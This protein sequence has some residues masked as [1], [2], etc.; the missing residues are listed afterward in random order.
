MRQG[1][2]NVSEPLL[3]SSLSSQQPMVCMTSLAMSTSYHWRH[4]SS[5]QKPVHSSLR[6]LRLSG[7]ATVRLKAADFPRSQFGTR[8]S[9]GRVP[10]FTFYLHWTTD[11]SLSAGFK[12]GISKLVVTGNYTL[13][14][15]GHGGMQIQV[16]CSEHPCTIQ[17]DL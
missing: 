12:K 9:A 14:T 4:A 3:P 11:A 17:G 7:N 13:I 8:R 16:L 15:L 2:E 5:V 10:Q 1:E 6:V